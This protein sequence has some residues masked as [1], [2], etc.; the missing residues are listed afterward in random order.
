MNVV[1]SAVHVALPAIGEAPIAGPIV[2]HV[3]SCLRCRAEIA[4]YRMSHDVLATL[5]AEVYRAPND[6]THNVMNGLGPVAVADLLPRRDNRL[7]VAAAAVFATA[8]AGTAVLVK[9][10][11]SRAA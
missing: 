10:Y 6:L 3:E 5:D 1:C 9:V 4:R 8:A 2:A 7:P 11:R